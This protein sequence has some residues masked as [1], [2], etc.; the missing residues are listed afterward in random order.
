MHLRR[1][2]IILLVFL[3]AACRGSVGTAPSDGQLLGGAV[4]GEVLHLSWYVSTLAG[5]A[6][7]SGTT[8]A[9]GTAAR[10]GHPE[11]L[12]SDGVHLYVV[13]TFNRTIR[14]IQ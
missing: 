4:Q 6:G 5:S 12:T 3:L 9:L 8:D 1:K 10:F 7:S 2:S 13:D 11:G 14:I